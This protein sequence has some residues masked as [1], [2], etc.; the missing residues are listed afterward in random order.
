MREDDPV[1][2]W[3]LVDDLLG[4]LDD[5]RARPQFER[6]HTPLEAAR[7]KQVVAVLDLA[8]LVGADVV[9]EAADRPVAVE[10]LGV[11]QVQVHVARRGAAA[12]VE[13][14][15]G[16]VVAQGVGERDDRPV[17]HLV[18]LALVDVLA[19]VIEVHQVADLQDHAQVQV[20]LVL[21]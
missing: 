3:V 14:R 5:R 13:D 19:L 15:R 8:G 16:V 21:G 1:H 18:R 20:G 2:V 9:D 10:L 4:P 7:A 12:V 17:Q 6:Q 11:A